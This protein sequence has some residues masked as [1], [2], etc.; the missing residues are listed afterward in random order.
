MEAEDGQHSVPCAWGQGRAGQHPS[1]TQLW[2]PV[3]ASWA[4][5]TAARPGESPLL[6]E[7]PAA[8]QG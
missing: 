8:A 4:E 6:P 3:L 2:P 1:E 7:V 5:P